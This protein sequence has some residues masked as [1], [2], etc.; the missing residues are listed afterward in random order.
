MTVLVLTH[1]GDTTADRVVAE[2]AVRG[3][4]VAR[5]DQARIPMRI[6]VTGRISS[7]GSWSGCLR[8]ADGADIDLAAVRVVWHR[9][10]RQ[11]VVDDRM[12]APEKAFAYGEARRGYGG[13]LA[14]LAGCLWIND[15]MAAARA[16]YK[17]VQLAAATAAGLRIPDTIITSDPAAA[18]AWATDLGRP[19]IYKPLSGGWHADEG[20]ARIIYTTPV[21]DL[22]TLLD[23]AISQTAHLFQEQIPKAFEARAVVAGDRGVHCQDRRGQRE[24]PPGLAQRLRCPHVHAHGPARGDRRRAGRAAPAAG[25]GLWRGGPGLYRSG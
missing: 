20:Q 16:E 19:V 24:Q 9:H 5:L 18:Y 15:P 1:D 8:D 3:I 23:P 6:S 14:A 13:I 7:G 22:G 4:P 21:T 2:L 10:T 11:F 17:P 25:P 12:S